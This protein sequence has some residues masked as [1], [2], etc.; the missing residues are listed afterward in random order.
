VARELA[1]VIHYFLEDTPAGRSP[2]APLVACPV[3]EKEA[4]R[5][6]FVWNLAVELARSGVRPS[7][8]VP[9]G[10]SVRDLLPAPAVGGVLA[11]ELVLSPARTLADFARDARGPRGS[12]G[13]R[14]EA[15]R[16]AVVPAEWVR[17]GGAAGLLAWTLLF[18]TPEPDD[19]EATQALAARVAAAEPGAE[20]GVVLHGVESVAESRAAF[21]QLAGRFEAEY[22]RPLRS[23]GLLLDDLLVYR[24]VVERRPVVLSHPQS[25]AARALADVARLLLGDLRGGGAGT[26][27]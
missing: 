21:G 5:L 18:A 25:L 24:A 2:E 3:G 15:V 4:V 7:L 14:E 12:R 20:V 22:G 16:L 26:A 1:D 19:L 13:P 27:E 17:G 11:P 9:E 6:A 8:V 23:Y 10:T